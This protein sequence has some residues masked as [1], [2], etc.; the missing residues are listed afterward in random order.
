MKK[1]FLLTTALVMASSVSFAGDYKTK[2]GAELFYLGGSVGRSSTDTGITEGTATLDEEDI[3]YK[4]YGGL[5]FNKYLGAEIH[6]IN[7]GEASL[8]GN[9]GSTFSIDGTN[10]TF[11]QNADISIS[12]QSFGLSGTL[13]Y[14]MGAVR[15]F[16]KGGLHR[17]DVDA[18]LNSAT[19]SADDNESGFDAVV[20]AGAE[21]TII[22][23]LNLRAEYEHYVLGSA[24]VN[25]LSAGINYRF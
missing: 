21:L 25:V 19:T 22:G 1:T 3:S 15:P 23:G 11:N 2:R 24:D 12:G 18:S 7:F 9:N 14:K 17:W 6:Y 13:G 16:V 10:Y 8:S 5:Q 20:G 4:V